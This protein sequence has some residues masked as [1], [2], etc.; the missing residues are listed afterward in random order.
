MRTEQHTEQPEIAYRA[1]WY[2][3]AY[4]CKTYETIARHSICDGR[5]MTYSAASDAGDILAIIKGYDCYRIVKE[6]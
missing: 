1:K 5:I 4:N 2:L 3:E 6:G